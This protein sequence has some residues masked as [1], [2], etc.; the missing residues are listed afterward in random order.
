MRISVAIFTLNEEVNLPHCLDSLTDCDDVVVIDS[1]SKDRTPEIAREGGARVIEHEFTGFG[2]QRKWALD[3]VEFKHPWVLILDADEKVTP[4]LWEEMV[5]KAS[6]ASDGVAAFQLKRRFYW[7]GKRLRYANLY[8]SW[9]VRLVRRGRVHYRNRGHAETQEID[10][11]IESLEHDLLDENH[12]GIQAWRER[13]VVYAEQEA[14]YE[15]QG[16]QKVSLAQLRSKDPL[17]KRAAWKMLARRIPCRGVSYFIYAYFLRKG[18]LDGWIG[19][20]FCFEKARFQS[21]I[22]QRAKSFKKLNLNR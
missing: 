22:Y 14:R 21:I 20:Q 4:E 16:N 12:K 15:S 19:L 7:N 2:D 9:G 1:F 17:T 11:R 18:F 3:Q 10:G 8:P 5:R 6:E 13:Q